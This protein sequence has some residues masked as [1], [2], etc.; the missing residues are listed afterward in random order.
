[1][2]LFRLLS[3]ESICGKYTLS[4]RQ[5]WKLYADWIASEAA[6]LWTEPAG[7]EARFA[8]LTAVDERSPKRWND[9]YLSA[10]AETADI[11]LVTFDKALAAKTAGAILL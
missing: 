4:L 2:G 6:E 9:A 7:L 10:F 8:Q 3:T 5:C 1:M 11:P